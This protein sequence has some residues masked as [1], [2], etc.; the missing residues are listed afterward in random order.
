MPCSSST[1]ARLY[2]SWPFAH[3]GAPDEHRLPQSGQD[4]AGEHLEV[5]RVTEERGFLHGDPVDEAL[6]RVAVVAQCVEVFVRV[7]PAAGG[8]VADAAAQPARAG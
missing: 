4:I 5:F 3:A 6:Q 8:V 7:L 1:I 2:A